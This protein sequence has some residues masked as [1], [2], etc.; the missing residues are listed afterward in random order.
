MPDARVSIEPSMAEQFGLERWSL[1]DDGG[2]LALGE[3]LT[4]R[5]KSHGWNVSE[6]MTVARYGPPDGL[7]SVLQWREPASEL[8]FSFIPGGTFRPGFNDAQI[9]QVA[10]LIRKDSDDDKMDVA[11]SELHSTLGQKEPVD[12]DP[13]LLAVEL[14]RPNLR[15]LRDVT[16]LPKG[17]EPGKP[18]YG[19]QFMGDAVEFRRNQVEPVLAHYGWS[20]LSSAEFEW[21]LRGGVSSLFY[22]GDEFPEF[23]DDVNVGWRKSL[24]PDQASAK[25]SFDAIMSAAFDPQRPRAWPEFNRFG[26][27]A[28]LPRQTWC[29]ASSAPGDT[30]PRVVRGGAAHLYPWQGGCFEWMMLL[31]ASENSVDPK[32]GSSTG[33][34]GPPP[35]AAIRPMIRLDATDSANGG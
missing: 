3:S 22:W 19:F 16:E 26:L 1:L 20:L 21:A 34:F 25:A 28:M 35:T 18:L 13:F 10:A 2:K 4:G 12:I 6:P 15:G 33:R 17:S 9:A 31:S 24:R 27:A 8:M 5:L 23:M 30:T 11:E 14:V 7:Q 29:G 32:K